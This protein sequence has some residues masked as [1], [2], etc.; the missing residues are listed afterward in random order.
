MIRLVLF[1]SSGSVDGDA[2]PPGPGDSLDE[3][4]EVCREGCG[5]N[6]TMLVLLLLMLL[7]C[8]VGICC[9]TLCCDM[10]CCCCCIMASACFC[11]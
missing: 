3:D 7:H 4:E 9:G 10:A 11:R 6:D 5:F 2:E 1:S 8:M